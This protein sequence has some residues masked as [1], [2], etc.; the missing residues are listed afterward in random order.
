MNQQLQLLEGLTDALL[1]IDPSGQC[2]H[3][4]QNASELFNYA[5]DKLSEATMGRPRFSLDV[6]GRLLDMYAETVFPERIDKAIVERF[7]KKEIHTILQID[8]LPEISIKLVTH[9]AKNPGKTSSELA[10]SLGI[11]LGNLNKYTGPLEEKRL[12]YI[13]KKG[14]STCHYAFGFG[15]LL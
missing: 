9:I 4:N 10:K 12:I 8:N 14:R 5:I 1:L 15:K 2:L 11:H 3:C 7:A 6:A 13:E